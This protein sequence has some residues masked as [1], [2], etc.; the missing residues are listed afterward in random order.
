MSGGS[1]RWKQKASPTAIG[2]AALSGYTR[3]FTPVRRQLKAGGSHDWLPHKSGSLRRTQADETGEA[4]SDRCRNG[5]RCSRSD[6]CRRPPAIGPRH[7]VGTATGAAAVGVPERPH[8]IAVKQVTPPFPTAAKKPPIPLRH[9]H[10][11]PLHSMHKR[12][13]ACQSCNRPGATAL[14]RPG[15]LAHGLTPAKAPTSASIGKGAKI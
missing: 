7:R 5:G 14:G 13:L 4:P 1:P 8:S 10:H 11:P 12:A 9:G 2:Q 15:E 6:V 3:T